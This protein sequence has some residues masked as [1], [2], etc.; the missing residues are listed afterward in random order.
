MLVLRDAQDR[1]LLERRP[2]VGVWAGLWS[3][4]E[5]AD[6]TSAHRHVALRAKAI[7]AGATFT[8]LA[9]FVHGF[10]HYR[11]AVTPLLLRVNAANAV[12][13]DEHSRWLS[14]AQAAKLGLPA[15]VRKL[16]ASLEET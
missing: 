1:I 5:A 16:I 4:P 10:S 11:L 3:L 8:P 13:D 2:P 14:L 7:A 6:E 12:A 15:P 9:N